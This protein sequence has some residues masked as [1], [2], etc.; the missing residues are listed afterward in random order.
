MNEPSVENIEKII[1]DKLVKDNSSTKLTPLK[2]FNL[3]NYA[4]KRASFCNSAS[5][6]YENILNSNPSKRLFRGSSITDVKCTN[7]GSFADSLCFGE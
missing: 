1:K 3:Q 6:N 4:N 7:F 2:E 5:S